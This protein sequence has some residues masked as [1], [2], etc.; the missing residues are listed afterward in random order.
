MASFNI[1][2]LEFYP[3][4]QPKYV[5]EIGINHQGDYEQ[6]RDMAYAAK[7]A[8]ADIVKFQTHILEAEMLPSHP[9][10]DVISSC[11]IT[12]GEHQLLKTHCECI[13]LVFLSTPFSLAAVDLLSSLGVSA[14]K[15]GSGELTH[16]PL[17]EKIAKLGL[18]T[19]ISTGMSTIKEVE[20]TIQT[21]IPYNRK[22]ILM[23]CTSTYPTTPSAARIHRIDRFYQM[24][25]GLL[26]GQSDH[27][28][29][30][31]TALGA[32]ARG[33]VLIEKHFTLDKNMEGPDHKV[34]LIPSEFKQMV[35]LGNEVWQSTQMAPDDQAIEGLDQVKVW[36]EHQMV[37][38]H[39]VREGDWVDYASVNFKRTANL[40]A[41]PAA[42]F[43][44]LVPGARFKRDLPAN[45][46]ILPTDIQY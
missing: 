22:L 27:T 5:A 30:I 12:K 43:Y 9:L 6:A 14:F 39:H 3:G 4:C 36:A 10:W 21:V 23:N 2:H 1:D 40:D 35:E 20:R 18:P 7:D 37:T 25:T 16:L 38:D 45:S 13:G 44:E 28:P 33:A 15:T 31:A 34:S 19:I 42:K 41:I 17:Q 24:G 8:G 11:T 32:I 46:P 26:V 29:T